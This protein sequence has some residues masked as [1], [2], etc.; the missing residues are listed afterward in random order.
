LRQ[1][2]LTAHYARFATARGGGLLECPALCDGGVGYFGGRARQGSDG[3]A[4]PGSTSD[5]ISDCLGVKRDVGGTRT[6]RPR[7]VMDVL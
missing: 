3:A 2:E 6:T 1:H 7:E 4:A 5:G